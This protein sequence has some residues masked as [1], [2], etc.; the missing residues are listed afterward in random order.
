MRVIGTSVIGAYHVRRV[1]LLMAR[2]LLLYRM[3]LGAQLDGTMLAR[4]PLH[5]SEIVQRIKEAMEESD[6]TFPIL[7]HP[8]M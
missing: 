6:A 8:A 5:N 2:A 1:M 7:G 3:T 4:G